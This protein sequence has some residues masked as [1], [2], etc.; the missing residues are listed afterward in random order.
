MPSENVNKQSDFTFP[1]LDLLNP[2]EKVNHQQFDSDVMEQCRKLE[3]TLAD[4]CVS[5]KVIGVTRGPTV[6]RYELESAPGIK[7]STVVNLADDIAFRLAVPIIRVEPRSAKSHRLHITAP[8]GDGLVFRLVHKAIVDH[9]SEVDD[10]PGVATLRQ[11]ICQ[12]EGRTVLMTAH[13]DIPVGD[14]V[15]ALHLGVGRDDAF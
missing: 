7:V 13:L 4:F 6:T 2:V 5:A 3:Q 14:A 15:V 8:G 12:V 1:S 9:R 10:E 11:R